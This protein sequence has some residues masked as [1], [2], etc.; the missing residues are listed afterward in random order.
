[1]SVI[2][3][4]KKLVFGKPETRKERT[5]RKGTEIPG[6]RGEVLNAGTFYSDCSWQDFCSGRNQNVR[7]GKHHQMYI[8]ATL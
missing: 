7:R 3:D 4:K 2:V 5:V 6:R 8:I 1:M